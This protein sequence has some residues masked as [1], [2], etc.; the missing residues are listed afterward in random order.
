VIVLAPL[1]GDITQADPIRVSS[2]SLVDLAGSEN[3]KMADVKG[4]RQQEARFIN[5]SLLTLSELIM[6]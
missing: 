1:N 6:H 2:L 4:P 5:Q 3:A